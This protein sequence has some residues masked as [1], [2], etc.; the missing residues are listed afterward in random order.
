[1]PPQTTTAE[2]GMER[3]GEQRGKEQRD[4]RKLQSN[5]DT[6]VLTP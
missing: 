4:E 5:L 1:M 6:P 2:G 3:H